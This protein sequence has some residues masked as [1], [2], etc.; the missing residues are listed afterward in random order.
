[1]E[2]S[3]VDIVVFD[4]STVNELEICEI[5]RQDTVILRDSVDTPMSSSKV[6]LKNIV[7][8][9]WETKPYTGR[10]VAAHKCGNIIAYTIKAKNHE[11]IEGMIRIVNVEN[12]KRTLL[13]GMNSEAL[14]LEFAFL[15]DLI[16]L[17]YINDSTLYVQKIEESDD[18]L[19]SSIV[20][21][22]EN[23][24]EHVNTYDK[25]TWCPYIPESAFESDTYASQ[26]LTWSRGSTFHCYSITDIT[27][28]YGNG[29]HKASDIEEGSLTFKE[30]KSNILDIG[31]S[32]DGTTLAT[33]TQD[34]YVRFY[35]VY[36]HSLDGTP[37]RL[38]EWIP[39][40]GKPVKKIMFL[41]NLNQNTTDEP[42]WKNAITF[43]EEKCEIKLWCCET[44]KCLQSIAFRNLIDVPV[45]LSLGLDKTA[46][47]MVVSDMYDQQ[48]YVFHIDKSIVNTSENQDK[49]TCIK[50]VAK[51]PLA[52]QILSFDIV[53]ANVQE[54]KSSLSDAYITNE[55]DEYDDDTNN[56][57]CIVLK[58]FL[59]QPKSVQ[60][61][62]LFYNQ[63][64]VQDV[65]NRNDATIGEVEKNEKQMI[66]NEGSKDTNQDN[67]QNFGIIKN[68]P[69][70]TEKHDDVSGK[71]SPSREVEK[72][73][74]EVD[75][76]EKYFEAVTETILEVKNIETDVAVSEKEQK[77]D[78]TNKEIQ[79]S[80]SDFNIPTLSTL[81]LNQSKQLNDMK[82]TINAIQKN[83]EMINQQAKYSNSLFKTT[84]NTNDD[85]TINKI[86]KLINNTKSEITSHLEGSLSEN[87]KNIVKTLDNSISLQMQKVSK[88]INSQIDT[89]FRSYI[90][91]ENK[92]LGD[93]KMDINMTIEKTISTLISNSLI[94]SFETIS[95]EMIFQFNKTIMSTTQEYT[96]LFEK[97][98]K[99][100]TLTNDSSE[101][102]LLKSQQNLMKTEEVLK[103][104]LN[105]LSKDI[106]TMEAHISRTIK[107]QIKN[108]VQKQFLEQTSAIRSSVLSAVRTQT[109]VP[110]SQNIQ[111]NICRLLDQGQ[112]NKAFHLA[113]I[114]NDLTLVEYTIKK[115]DFDTVFHPCNLEQTVLLSLIQQ[116]SAD[117]KQHS[118]LKQ[119]YLAEAIIN[120]NLED[121]SIKEHAPRIM[122]ELRQNCKTFVAENPNNYLTSYV[123]MLILASQSVA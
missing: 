88:D 79:I 23:G 85:H 95:K 22:L 52:S 66:L 48:M 106:K 46:S 37:R 5:K 2:S 93:N 76:Y 36:L 21:Q 97:H 35:Q 67:N 28:K 41:D 91:K 31:F 74:N 3:E 39:H 102:F 54:N 57:Q 104:N 105:S 122:T 8:Y 17:A 32:P 38:H 44:W 18:Q 49:K 47:Y 77:N 117:M 119:K 113:L 92:K 75:T 78:Y 101:Q 40:D 98:A 100:N 6:K 53:S 70:P 114:A 82:E 24:I 16:L 20:L 42:L 64:A 116:L 110:S 123:K 81:F 73:L 72:I 27:W 45:H 10:L 115:A 90:E 25:V 121:S 80:N 15:D 14:D 7:D 71:S 62:N 83:M 107:D 26:L 120:L 9:K 63:I 51:F 96:K 43:S 60:E 112:I 103:L 69:I 58:M 89:K 12:G 29:P 11:K 1:M 109:P 59:V 33:C 84:D 99:F 118:E 108:E 68:S 50:S 86:E 111:S 65:Q 56:T 19:S 34:G 87:L 61:C 94:P 55:I 4:K 30:L 13:K